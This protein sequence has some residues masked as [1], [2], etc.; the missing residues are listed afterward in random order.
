[1]RINADLVNSINENFVELGGTWLWTD[2]DIY[3]FD[4][5]EVL[6]QPVSLDVVTTDFLRFKDDEVTLTIRSGITSAT[7]LVYLATIQTLPDSD[8]Q[9]VLGFSVGCSDPFLRDLVDNGDG[10]I[11]ISACNVYLLDN[12][13]GRGFVTNYSF[14]PATLTIPDNV[15]SYIC[16]KYNSGSPEIY[17]ETNKAN[18]NE[19]NIVCLYICWRIGNIIH[20]IGRDSK[21]LNLSN[22][23]AHSILNTKPYSKSVDGG[24]SLSESSRNILVTSAVVFSGIVQQN[25]A[26]FNS[27]TDKLTL[28]YHSSGVWNYSSSASVYNNT[29]Y[30]DGTNLQTIPNNKFSNRYLY[31]SIGDIREVFYTLGTTYYNNIESAKLEMPR[32]DLPIVVKNHGYLVGRIIIQ[33]NASSGYVENV[34]DQVLIPSQVVDHNNLNGL[35]GGS[36]TER[37]HLSASTYNYLQSVSANIQDQIN[38]TNFNLRTSSTSLQNQINTLAQQSISGM[39]AG[40]IN[41]VG[42]FVTSGSLGDSSINDDGSL[43]KIYNPLSASGNISANSFVKIGGTSSQFLKADGSVD[44]NVYITSSSLTPYTLTTTTSAISGS[45][46][47]QLNNLSA[48]YTTRTEVSAVSGNLQNQINNNNNK[49]SAY[50]PLSGGTLTGILKGTSVSASGNVSG[51]NFVGNLNGFKNVDF[52]NE[53]IIA[54]GYSNSVGNLYI[55]YRGA[56]SAIKQYNF[57]NGLSTGAYSG[58]LASAFVK[59]G[60]TSAQYLKA[61]GSVSNGDELKTKYLHLSGGN[62]YGSTTFG[63]SSNNAY[64]NLRTNGTS[65]GQGD[66]NFLGSTSANRRFTFRYNETNDAFELFTSNDNGTS[67]SNKM[68]MYRNSSSATY[69]YTGLNVATGNLSVQSL[70]ASKLVATNAS[71]ELISYNLTSADIPN[72]PQYTLTT[73]T[74]A[75]SANL[76]TQITNNNNKLS[77]YLPLSGGTLTGQLLVK[78]QLSA[79]G[80]LIG[81]R[82]II[83]G[84][85]STQFL[86]ADGS[87][88]S[89]SYALDTLGDYYLPLSGGT[90]TG[91]LVTS[92]VRPISPN[93]Y[94]LGTVFFPYLSLYVSAI[95]ANKINMEGSI[96]PINSILY[97]L[98]SNSNKW[99]TIY[100]RDLKSV[101]MSTVFDRAVEAVDVKSHILLGFDNQ[102]APHLNFST[103][104]G[105]SANLSGDFYFDGL[106][107]KIRDKNSVLKTLSYTSDLSAYT[108]TS[109]FSQTISAYLPLSGGTL[110]GLLKGTSVSASGNV[111]G[112]NFVG[113]LEGYKNVDGGNE[114]TISNGFA[115]S[116]S[117]YINYRGATSAIKQY[118]FCNGLSTGAYSGILASAFIKSGGT[119]A[120]YLKADGSVSNGDEFSTKYLP[121]SGG[122]L[123]GNLIVKE[124]FIGTSS[125][126]DNAYFSHKLSVNDFP[127]IRQ[128]YDG[129]TKIDSNDDSGNDLGLDL[130]VLN[131]PKIKIRDNQTTISNTLNVANASISNLSVT[132]AFNFTGTAPTISAAD[133]LTN[134]VAALQTILENYGLIRMI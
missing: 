61:D 67:R 86:K 107:L 31:R 96:I 64:V 48:N 28:A 62:V 132:N 44:T 124:A 75:I 104:L 95:N 97:D 71:K 100:T 133:S 7:P 73:T 26:S 108:P 134:R 69:F 42:K 122:T 33:E 15:E 85:L 29:Q 76:Q 113:K 125:L 13:D 70:S 93:S 37:Y 21:G 45:L 59:N 24:L 27:S 56:T 111:S 52:G 130:C 19:S 63:N 131:D 129:F 10:T 72:L 18:I 90:L 120:Q 121:L 60:G 9:N 92:G 46:Q 127:A 38:T 25:V 110:T 112:V 35:Q 79:S 54:N 1:M 84:G 89:N 128:S 32:S 39:G 82:H 36:T 102:L 123:T 88:D 114:C 30:D 115:S 106:N 117:L 8:N 126:T 101:A 66:L 14:S 78:S 83:P 51:A 17:V 94:N 12:P 3:S 80:D 98:G 103:S 91:D 65:A 41:R 116:Q 49:L 43:V 20:S 53:C 5:L 4:Y 74:S 22:K 109:G 118:N 105:T 99:S 119:S 2:K 81:S 77:A 34:S 50:L 6:S 47:N 87:I 58:I 16:A 23:I 40:T 55:N 68:R 57:C 11:N